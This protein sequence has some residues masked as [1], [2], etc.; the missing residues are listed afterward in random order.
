MPPK[1][2]G[3]LERRNGLVLWHFRP[4]QTRAMPWCVRPGVVAIPLIL[5]DREVE[6]ARTQANSSSELFEQSNG[7][8]WRAAAKLAANKAQHID[9]RLDSACFEQDAQVLK[10]AQGEATNTDIAIV[11][12]LRFPCPLGQLC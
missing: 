1:A 11:A 2:L 8:Q 10:T 9:V 6:M 3:L 7:L 12:W 4:T 5:P